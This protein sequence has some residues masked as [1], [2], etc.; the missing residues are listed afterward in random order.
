VAVTGRDQKALAEVAAGIEKEGGR[1]IWV[2]AD[3]TRAPDLG[4][5][6]SAV[7]EQL[8]RWAPVSPWAGSPAR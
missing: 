5:L 1:V 3:C 4:A 2:A 8:G 7:G 6:A